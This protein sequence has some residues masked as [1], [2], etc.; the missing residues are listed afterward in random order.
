[1]RQ[2]TV[3]DDMQGVGE[4]LAVAGGVQ[5]YGYVKSNRQVDR[6]DDIHPLHQ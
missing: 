1:M 6:S 5:S 4:A 3:G 2:V